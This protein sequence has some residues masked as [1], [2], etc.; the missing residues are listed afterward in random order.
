MV[1]TFTEVSLLNIYIVEAHP[2]DGWQ[3]EANE[4]E[5]D[6]TGNLCFV[7]PKTLKA[8]LGV[9]KR[10]VAEMSLDQSTVVVDG[11]ENETDL[12]FEARPERLYVVAWGKILWR[13]GLGPFQYDTKGLEAF[14]A[15][16]WDQNGGPARL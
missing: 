9:A 15:E 2:T 4:A 11:I 13:S 16:H 14:L 3:V 6:G 10:F 5:D 12:A 7:Q 1:G 8:R